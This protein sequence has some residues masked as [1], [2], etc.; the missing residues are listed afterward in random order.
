MDLDAY[1][2]HVLRISELE[3]KIEEDG[4]YTLALISETVSS[5]SCPIFYRGLAPHLHHAHAGH[6]QAA[7]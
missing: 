7:P 4:I 5:F 2:S 1:E 3:S 6:T